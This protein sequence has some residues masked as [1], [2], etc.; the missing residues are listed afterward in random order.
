MSFQTNMDRT[1]TYIEDNLCE[2]IDY[3]VIAKNACCSIFHFQRV[4]SYIF[5][6][7]LAEY[8]RSRRMTLA[9]FD[10]QRT[11]MKICDLAVKYGYD[12]QA[13]FAR[14]FQAF[15][16][17]P[18]TKARTGGYVMQAFPRAYLSIDSNPEQSI[19]YRIEE[20]SA[21]VW[22]GKSIKIS[23]YEAKAD[24]L[25]HRAFEFGNEIICNGTHNKIVKQAGL[26]ENSY[27]TSIR[28]AFDE[29]GS[30]SFM[31][32]AEAGSLEINQEF[33]KLSVPNTLWAVF[34]HPAVIYPETTLSLYHRIYSEWFPTSGY[35]Q[36]EG[37]CMEKCNRDSIEIWLPITRGNNNKFY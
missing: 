30:H 26:K 33:E 17:C 7:P 10:L 32:G 16:G 29:D 15:H 19:S 20:T 27:L 9:A 13:S 11:D 14:A 3:K 35:V 12:S 21:S 5:G 22:F 2:T 34:S 18:P 37:A 31:F 28:Y 1:I 6:I 4:F 36:V 8:I 23:A 25:F 24:Q